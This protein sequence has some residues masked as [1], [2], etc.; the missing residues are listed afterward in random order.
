MNC[1]TSRS[2]SGVAKPVMPSIMRRTPTGGSSQFIV[3]RGVGGVRNDRNS[4][5]EDVG[6]DRARLVFVALI[7][8]KSLLLR[9]GVVA[10]RAEQPDQIAAQLSGQLALAGVRRVPKVR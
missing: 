2:S 4:G 5:G 7:N 9:L 6:I 10:Q 8:A 1:C 3:T